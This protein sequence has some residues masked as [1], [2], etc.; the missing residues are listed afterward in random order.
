M[1]QPNTLPT[2]AFFA[3]MRLLLQ[4]RSLLKV[5]RT[6]GEEFR[7]MGREAHAPCTHTREFARAAVYMCGIGERGS[8]FW[9]DVAGFLGN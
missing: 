9:G 1:L 5:H 8:V 2:L 6:E 3:L 7:M 4:S